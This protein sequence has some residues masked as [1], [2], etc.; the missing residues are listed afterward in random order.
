MKITWKKILLFLSIFLIT[1]GIL[2]T[3]ASAAEAISIDAVKE[4]GEVTVHYPEDMFLNEEA[5]VVCYNEGWNQDVEDLVSNLEYAVYLDQKTLSSESGTISFTINEDAEIGKTYYLVIGAASKSDAIVLEFEFT[6]SSTEPEEPRTYTVTYNSNGGSVAPSSQTKIHGE[7]LTLSSAKLTRSGYTFLGWSTS[8]SAKN[9]SYQAGDSYTANEDITLY[10]VWKAKTYTIR[11]DANGGSGAPS[12]QMKTHGYTLT[13]SST[14]PTRSGYTFL[15]WSTSRSAKNASYLAGDSYTAN[16]DITLYAV[17][18]KNETKTYTIRY[19][20]N[21]GSG[22]P[23]NQT[24][25]HGV[26]LTLRAMTPIRSG[27]TFAGWSTS[28][29]GTIAIYQPEDIYEADADLALYAVWKIKSDEAV[30]V[31]RVFGD[32][33]YDTAFETAKA[34]KNEMSV[35]KFKAV[36]V[37][38]GTNFPDALSG[39]YLAAEAEAPIIL[40]NGKNLDRVRT[41]IK[42]NVITNG[43]VYLLGDGGVVPDEITDGL[44]SYRI[45][46]LGGA[47]RYETNLAIL[48]Q[49]GVA[50]RD[51]LVCTGRDYADSLSAASTGLPILIVKDK[52]NASQK[53]FLQTIEGDIY[54]IGGDAAVNEYVENELKAYGNVKRIGGASRYETSVLIAEEFFENPN[55]AVLAYSK[56]FPDGLCGGAL[57]Y[58]MSAPLI[59]TATG[60]EEAAGRYV[61]GQN[62]EKGY[63][64]GSSDLISDDAVKIIFGLEDHESILVQ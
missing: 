53:K 22:A 48:N 8:R 7:T 12:S 61:N 49:V 23:Q 21:G 31:I 43:T 17:W 34:L 47:T 24:K 52:L 51:L 16:E 19:D 45:I 50:G 11:Y 55:A 9:A 36:I 54:V 38:C 14:K 5:S 15:G 2:S 32:T 25:T 46:R 33:R 62:I 28:K 60:K 41:Y 57:A 35:E 27:Y 1:N 37:T 20:A 59:L 26:A 42:Q 6:S 39:T 4:S 10:A 3:A 18:E 56:N 64:L 13:L 44:S 63:V 40:T 58:D 29:D 30:N